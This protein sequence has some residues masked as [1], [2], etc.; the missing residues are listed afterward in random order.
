MAL[1]LLLE[2]LLLL[3]FVTLDLFLFYIFFESVLIPMFLI[4]GIWGSRSRKIKAAYYFFLYTLLGSLFMLIAIVA[5]LLEIGSTSY[6]IL[7]LSN[8]S[9]EKQKIL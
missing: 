1:L 3:S 9:L 8:F 4:I 6:D 2:L 7:L 5:I